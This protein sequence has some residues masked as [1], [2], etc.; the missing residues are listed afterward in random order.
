MRR[1]FV[2]LTAVALALSAC[3]DGGSDVRPYAEAI[4]DGVQADE[5][6]DS[7]QTSDD[8]ARC[9]GD[10]TVEVIGLDVLEEAGTPEEVTELA[11][12]DL[13]AFEL[14]DDQATEIARIT[15]ECVDDMLGQF[16]ESFETESVEADACLAESIGETQIVPLL[17]RSL[18]GADLSD[19]ESAGLIQDLESA[20]QTCA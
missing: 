17:A 14:D 9:I 10:G 3:G 5:G 7:L 6:D 11:Q 20:F 19:P 13:S 8:E 18:Q 2:A 1:F 4:A 15:Y 12:D 16:I